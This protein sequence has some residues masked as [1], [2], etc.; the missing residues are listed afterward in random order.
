MVEKI[1]EP[2]E[3]LP[4]W[5]VAG[6]TGYDAMAEVDGV[7]V[8]PA[9]EAAFTALDDAADRRSARPGR[10]WCTTASWTVATG[11]L[12]AEVRRLAALVPEI[13]GRRGALAELL[14]CF[15]VY[16]SYLPVGAGAPGPRRWP[17]P[18]GAGRT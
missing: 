13:A 5:P 18:A 14:A 11:L 7:F 12:A 9:G 10:T 2:G 3:R 16:R 6:T 8:D 4:D 1:L 15:P 17:R